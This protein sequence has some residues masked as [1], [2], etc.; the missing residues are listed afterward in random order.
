MY[1]DDYISLLNAIKDA[2]EVISPASVSVNRSYATKE[3]SNV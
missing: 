3:F 1:F 2:G